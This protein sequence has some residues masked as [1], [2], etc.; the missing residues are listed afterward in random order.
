MTSFA[1][2]EIERA[3][4]D[5]A[6]A[7]VKQTLDALERNLPLARFAYTTSLD[8]ETRDRIRRLRAE[9]HPRTKYIDAF[10]GKPCQ[11]RRCKRRRVVAP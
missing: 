6:R 1:M 11:C 2:K 3:A 8:E 7:A 9:L 4:G 5:L 10:G